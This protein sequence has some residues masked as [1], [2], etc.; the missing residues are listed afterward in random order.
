MFGQKIQL[1]LWRLIRQFLDF[2]A[3]IIGLRFQTQRLY[4]P[5]IT[6]RI[7][8]EPAVVLSARIKSG[9]LKCETLVRA[10]IARCR[11][12]QPHINAIIANRYESA[13]TEAQVVDRRVRAELDGQ[14]PVLNGQSIHSQPLLGIPFT[15]KDSFSVLGMPWTSGLYARKGITGPTD[16]R[17][18]ELL[19]NAGAIMIAMT[20]VPELIMWWHSTN[21]LYGRTNNP[22]DKSRVPGGSSGGECALMASAGSLIGVGSDIGGSIR[23]PSY[24]CGVFGH[25]TTNGVVST[26]GIYPEFGNKK[27]KL[28]CVG[29]YAADLKPVLKM[30]AGDNA[31][32]LQLDKT[33]NIKNIKVYYMEGHNN[34]GVIPVQPDVKQKLLKC[35]DY[36]RDKCAD[37]EP[38]YLKE[39][40]LGFD[41]WMCAMTDSKA[42]ALERELANLD[43]SI[44]PYIELC[45]SMFG[46]SKVIME[47]SSQVKVSTPLATLCAALPTEFVAYLEYCRR[48]GFK[49]TPD[50]RY[51]RRLFRTLAHNKG[52]AYDNDFDWK[53]V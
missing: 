11:E 49:S 28:L 19:R 10:Y 20:N 3:V 14:N 38:L 1:K 50:Y 35:V 24:F 30:M 9:K 5:P 48:L 36:L 37:C 22:Y 16:S 39:L 6:D 2:I 31:P 32:K 34:P 12:V 27:Q 7:L 44:N 21:I 33:F 40:E 18:I 47:Y 43:G 15:C 13:I 46:L 42:P 45:K 29:P 26:H 52:Y 25:K 53:H 4:L 41:I 17:V 51:L 23:E 8:L